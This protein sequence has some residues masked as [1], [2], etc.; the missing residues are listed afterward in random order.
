M[1]PVPRLAFRG[2]ERR[3]LKNFGF[4]VAGTNASQ[5]SSGLPPMSSDQLSES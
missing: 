1:T 4:S 3:Q 2:A 5:A